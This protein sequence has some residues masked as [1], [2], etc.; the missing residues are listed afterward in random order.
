[1]FDSVLEMFKSQAPVLLF[2]LAAY[3]LSILALVMVSVKV[4]VY[5]LKEKFVLSRLINGLVEATLDSAS[6]FVYLLSIITFM[7]VTGEAGILKDG[8]AEQFGIV[9]LLYILGNGTIK[10]LAAYQLK[11]K[12]E[13]GV[14]DAVEQADGISGTSEDL[15]EE[16]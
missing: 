6:L 5:E 1:M 11:K 16:G 3:V 15:T 2:G 9:A 12:E 14:K 8:I 7:V 13:I 4:N 10:N